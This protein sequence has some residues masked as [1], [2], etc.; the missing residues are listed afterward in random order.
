MLALLL[1]GRVIQFLETEAI[2]PTGRGT[3]MTAPELI[4]NLWCANTF[5]Q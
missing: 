4:E 3:T 1:A 2:P 5:Q